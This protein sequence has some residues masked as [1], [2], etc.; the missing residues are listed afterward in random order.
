M[1]HDIIAIGMLVD[2]HWIKKILKITAPD[3]FYN[4]VKLNLLAC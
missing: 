4:K 2:Q 1:T 3:Y